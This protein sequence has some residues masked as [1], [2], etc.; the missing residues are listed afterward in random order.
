MLYLK[1]S[2]FSTCFKRL[3][4]FVFISFFIFWDKDWLSHP[5]CSASGTILTLQ[6]LPL[7]LKPSSDLS[8][9]SSWDYRHMPPC[10]ASFLLFFVETG[11]HY[12]AQAGLNLLGLRDPPASASQSIGITGISHSI[13]P[14]MSLKGVHNHSKV[15][16]SPQLTN[17]GIKQDLVAFSSL[18]KASTMLLG[19]HLTKL[20][21]GSNTLFK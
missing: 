6:P 1:K 4:Y 15:L 9:P 5:G 17:A 21:I 14:P 2:I 16:Q 3:P 7:G 11:S 10:Q 20:L 8:L 13:W 19:S 12:V 18:P